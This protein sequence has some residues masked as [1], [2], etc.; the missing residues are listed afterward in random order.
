MLPDGVRAEVWLKGL[1]MVLG[2][3]P[4]R[5]LPWQFLQMCPGRTLYV[6]HASLRAGHGEL[7]ASIL[8]N[9]AS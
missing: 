6:R 1:P 8:I 3:E 2:S 9:F 4:F 7:G 5:F